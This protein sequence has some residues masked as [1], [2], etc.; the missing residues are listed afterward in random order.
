MKRLPG[1]LMGAGNR[2]VSVMCTDVSVLL[3]MPRNRVAAGCEKLSH[4]TTLFDRDVVTSMS[5]V[6]ATELG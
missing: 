2:S 1:K 5:G 6:G 3:V 4:S